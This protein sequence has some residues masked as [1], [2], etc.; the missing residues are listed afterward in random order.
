M[1]IEE[2]IKT[3]LNR[4]SVII[5]S[6]MLALSLSLAF[7]MGYL[8]GQTGNRAPIVIEQVD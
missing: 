7:G 1:Q 6:V 8:I 4:K 3:N 2:Y 5:W